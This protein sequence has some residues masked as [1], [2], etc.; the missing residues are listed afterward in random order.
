VKTQVVT[1]GFC[2]VSDLELYYAAGFFGYAN[3]KLL[4]CSYFL[5]G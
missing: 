2:A 3:I 1:A 5:T 4:S